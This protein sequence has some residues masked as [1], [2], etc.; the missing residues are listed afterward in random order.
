MGSVAPSELGAASGTF[1]MSRQLGGAF[2]LAVAVAVFS[3]AGSYASPSAF[4]AGFGPAIGVSASLSLL[5]VL[6][7]LSLR[8]RRVSEAVRAAEVAA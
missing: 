2:G 4:S 1:S 7:G 3:G 8:G 5:G 6:A